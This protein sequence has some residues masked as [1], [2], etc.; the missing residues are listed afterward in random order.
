M[1]IG[2]SIGLNSMTGVGPSGGAAAFDDFIPVIFDIGQSNSIGRA[3][4]DRLAL[5]TYSKTPAGVK[6][7]YKTAYGAAD[8][9]TW[10]DIDTATNCKEPD[11]AGSQRTF[12][13]YLA[14]ATDLR[15]LLG[16]NVYVIAAGD[17][18]T[19]LTDSGI[20]ANNWD[21]DTVGSCFDRAIDQYFSV[22]ITKLQ[23][24]F[25]GREIRVFISWHQGESDAGDA[26]ATTAYSTNFPL[27]ITALRSAHALLATAP[28]FITKLWYLK[29]ANETTLNNYFISY[30]AAN[31]SLVRLI[32]VSD[33]PQKDE[34]TPEQ[35]G[36]FTATISDDNHQSYLG[37]IAKGQRIC[38]ALVSLAG[39]VQQKPTNYSVPT[40]SG[41]VKVGNTLTAATGTWLGTTG[42]SYTY[43]WRRDGVS[44]SGATSSTYE[45]V[46]AD[47]NALITVAV[48]G[49]NAAGGNTA[50]SAATSAVLPANPVNT[51]APVVSGTEVV[52]QT[53]SC[54]TGTWTSSA[55]L[56]YAYQWKRGVTNVGTD[57]STYIL[58]IGDAA[59]T[60]TCTVT[61]TNTGGSTD[62]VSNTT[63][64]IDA[65]GAVPVNL[66][67]PA[68][69]PS[70]PPVYA[71]QLLTTTDGTWS[72]SPTSYSYA[73][74]SSGVPVGTDQ[75]TYT[76]TENEVTTDITCIVTATNASG[77]GTPT[78]GN[79]VAIAAKAVP[80]YVAAG[81]AQ[82]GVGGSTIPLPA[83]TQADDILII[84]I[85]TSNNTITVPSGWAHVTGSPQ[86]TGTSDAIGST[87]INAIWK[88]HSGSEA[89][90]TFADPGE[91]HSAQMHAW[92]GVLT[93][94][95]PGANG[96]GSANAS[97][98]TAFSASGPTTTIHNELLII[99]VG[100]GID[101]ST[102]R[103]A[104]HGLSGTGVTSVNLRRD[105][106][107]NAGAG[108]GFAVWDGTVATPGAVTT[109]TA[110]TTN[111]TEMAWVLFSLKPA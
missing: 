39:F 110:T 99:A 81:T 32:D 78:V 83:G 17:G 88:K 94:A 59:S 104:S 35:I 11:A 48:R 95:S 63:G 9:G 50:I 102:A 69:S 52:G 87:G 20:T 74:W 97:A 103:W 90:V 64:T 68:I 42:I 109:V 80:T 73:W 108:G 60:M 92:R 101:S 65:G 22:A 1:K 37:Q 7:Y 53:L 56:T 33:Q 96:V 47:Y 76:V 24:D 13:G 51:V 79:T 16:R 41:T 62:Q 12:G 44:I 10:Q 84:F 100:T 54:T 4:S 27:F 31:T 21:P 46:T 70:T 8:N 28:L 66:V 93:S 14:F 2:V 111:A 30:Q 19:A 106:S 5:T 57:S 40:I 58:V 71:E 34:L 72:N 18:S 107:V 75:N 85:E 91:H 89:S 38:T 55:S 82:S 23:T 98:T 29:S 61:A 43:Q 49:T 67:A 6:I 86:G 15:D 26:A 45:L 105:A 36:G 25:P 77:S 3:E